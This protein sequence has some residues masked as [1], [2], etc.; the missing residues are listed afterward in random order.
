MSHGALAV[1]GYVERTWGYSSPSTEASAQTEAIGY[2]L[3][4]LLKG[5][6]VGWAMESLRMRCA[7]LATQLVTT[8]EELEFDKDFISLY[9]LAQMWTYCNDARSCVVIG[10]P[11]VRS[12]CALF[13][14]SRRL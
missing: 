4:E 3:Q 7:G 11:A 2:M 13:G 14:K 5:W 1:V 10:D 6:P 8:V 12:P 9:D